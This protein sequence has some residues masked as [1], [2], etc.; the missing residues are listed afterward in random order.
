[1]IGADIAAELPVFQERAESLMQDDC[2][3]TRPSGTKSIDPS[4][5]LPVSDPPA[6]VYGGTGDHGKDKCKVQSRAREVS[7]RGAGVHVYDVQ[8]L[9]L[10][11]PVAATGV[12]VD[13]IAEITASASDPAQVGRKFKVTGVSRKT[14]ATAQRLPVEEVVA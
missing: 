9:D 2:V 13:D 14:F 11:I 12:R 10:H 1:M 6:T 7:N 3:I 8:Q 4:T 5:G